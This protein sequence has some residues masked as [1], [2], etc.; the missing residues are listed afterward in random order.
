MNTLNVFKLYYISW[1]QKN[2]TRKYTEFGCLK[3]NLNKY[4]SILKKSNIED[5]LSN[6]NSSMYLDIWEKVCTKKREYFLAKIYDNISNIVEDASNILFYLS[7]QDMSDYYGY[8]GADFNYCGEN[9]EP[10]LT[11]I[12]KN[13][14]LVARKLDFQLYNN[15]VNDITRSVRLKNSNSTLEKD[16]WNTLKTDSYGKV[17]STPQS[18]ITLDNLSNNPDIISEISDFYNALLYIDINKGGKCI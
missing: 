14:L 2:G 10:S 7:S 5:F 1:H 8:T 16:L 13:L 17:H 15:I 18:Y 3:S 11:K 6:F 9:Y 4:E 12:Y